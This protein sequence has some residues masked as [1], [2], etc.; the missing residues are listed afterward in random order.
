MLPRGLTQRQIGILRCC[1]PTRKHPNEMYVSRLL[2]LTVNQCIFLQGK[3][4]DAPFLRK[5][6]GALFLLININARGT[7]KV[8]SPL[9]LMTQIPFIHR[10]SIQ[11]TLLLFHTL[12]TGIQSQT[13]ILTCYF[14]E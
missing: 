9:L 8:S 3:L 4:S 14:T 7:L 10:M 5:A 11:S 13:Q 6:R 2:L 1:K 12:K